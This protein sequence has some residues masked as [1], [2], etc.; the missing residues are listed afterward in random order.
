MT[1]TATHLPRRVLRNLLRDGS[2]TGLRPGWVPCGLQDGGATV[3][4]ITADAMAV[5]VR[6]SEAMGIAPTTLLEA[7]RRHAERDAHPG[8]DHLLYRIFEGGDR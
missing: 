3:R 7:Q 5:T 2:T 1:T 6:L 8:Y 4:V